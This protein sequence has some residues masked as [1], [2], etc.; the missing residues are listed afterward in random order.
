MSKLGV[1][2]VDGGDFMR[3]EQNARA[4][5]LALVYP[6]TGAEFGRAH[7]LAL[8]Y[9][10]TGAESVPRRVYENNLRWW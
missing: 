3:G 8:V 9:P 6:T 2:I 10:T 7:L 5:L 4:H 1:L